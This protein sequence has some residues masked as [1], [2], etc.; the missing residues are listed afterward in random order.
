[1]KKRRKY[2]KDFKLQVIEAVLRG[3][4]KRKA[5]QIFS[6]KS[7]SAISEWMVEYGIIYQEKS[8]AE[9]L[10]F[11]VMKN[12]QQIESD[13]KKIKE[14]EQQLKTAELK[15]LLYETM[16]KEAEKRLKIDIV[17]K[18]GAQQLKK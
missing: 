16:I 18:Y 1:M 7:N 4:S 9:N 5:N 15:A 14:L 12:T 17:K 2:Q 6:I 13:K 10:N 11:D 3:L 8:E